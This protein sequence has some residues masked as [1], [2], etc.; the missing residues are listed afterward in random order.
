MLPELEELRERLLRGGVKPGVAAR[1]VAEL[2]DHFEDLAAFVSRDEAWRRL[3]SKDILAEAMLAQPGVRSWTA[4]A[5]WAALTL[6]PVLALIVGFALPVLLLFLGVRAFAADLD[7]GRAALPGTWPFAVLDVLYMFGEH[8]LPLLVGW[9]FVAI[10]MRQRI[11]TGW[12]LLGAVLS[13]FLGAGFMMQVAWHTG[14]PA[15]FSFGVGF[16][17]ADFL[18]DV[19]GRS[20]EGGIFNLISILAPFAVLRRRTAFLG[21]ALLMMCG[22][23]CQAAGKTAVPKFV[24]SN[25]G[26]G[27]AA[28]MRGGEYLTKV[29]M[30]FLGMDPPLE[31]VDP[32]KTGEIFPDW[33]DEPVAMPASLSTIGVAHCGGGDFS[34][35]AAQL[36]NPAPSSEA[37]PRLDGLIRLDAPK[38]TSPAPSGTGLDMKSIYGEGCVSSGG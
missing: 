29:A 35:L 16:K 23:A 27:F 32:P 21:V 26:L 17:Y 18:T 33:V 4:R 3:G 13:A 10:A 37:A 25:N 24:S 12:A 11:R 30:H 7:Y 5:P 19:W 34:Q 1:Y 6:G 38:A 28:A 9:S 36:G 14:H 20:I 8:V 2:S 22:S 15:D 31:W